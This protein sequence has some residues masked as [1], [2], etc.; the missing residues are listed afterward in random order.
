[1]STWSST[2]PL[3]SSSTEATHMDTDPR[4][5]RS[6]PLPP[7]PSPKR[8]GG[9]SPLL[10][11][12]ASGR[13]PGGGV[14]R[15]TFLSST[16]GGVYGAALAYLL[17]LDAARGESR[18]PSRDGLEPR[19]TPPHF[20]G[21]ARAVIQIVAEGGPSQVDLFDP[22]P[23]L[24]KNHGKSIFHKIAEGVSAPEFAGA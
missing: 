4:H 13:G 2:R 21:K 10:P 17:G 23:G 14:D 16:A 24:D 22:K 11:L 15:R 7:A 8:R 1:M 12:S 18:A 20:P 5:H 19:P 9:E 3:S 6:Q